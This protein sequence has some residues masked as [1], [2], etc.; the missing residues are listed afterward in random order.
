MLKGIR[1]LVD[2]PHVS[3]AMQLLWEVCDILREA[4]VGP[5]T[6][7]PAS[8]AKVRGSGCSKR[9]C[10]LQGLRHTVLSKPC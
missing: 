3:A 4:A 1:K 6:P 2:L 9:T 7:T 10:T 8:A 5:A